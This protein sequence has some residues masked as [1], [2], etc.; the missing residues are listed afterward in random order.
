MCTS[1]T[2]TRSTDVRSTKPGSR[3]IPVPVNST[4]THTG[5]NPS[6]ASALSSASIP[7]GWSSGSSARS[8]GAHVC[9][10]TSSILPA[11]PDLVNTPPLPYSPIPSSGD[12]PQQ[13]ATTPPVAAISWSEADR[14][15]GRPLRSRHATQPSSRAQPPASGCHTASTADGLARC[16]T[17]AR[18]THPWN[19]CPPSSHRRHTASGV[20][21]RPPRRRGAGSRR[22]P[23]LKRAPGAAR[24]P[25]QARR[26]PPGTTSTALALARCTGLVDVLPHL[27]SYEPG[28]TPGRVH[29]R[30][31]QGL[32]VPLGTVPATRGAS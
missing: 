20:R 5:G 30:R 11:S 31:R 7:N 4:R 27:G 26:S 19:V 13:P 32:S 17:A 2:H 3:C 16:R 15:R 22:S 14:N 25:P 18:H 1:C 29:V 8:G 10:V 6:T 12:D 28:P 23:A 9:A 24:R 21:R